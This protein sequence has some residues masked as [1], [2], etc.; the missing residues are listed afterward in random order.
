MKSGADL[1]RELIEKADHDLAAASIGARHGAPRDA[2]CFHVQQA[3]EK[4]LKAR[5]S[6]AGVPYPLTHDLDELLAL[7]TP[8]FPAVAAFVDRFESVAPC[9]VELRYSTS[10]YPSEE[11]V[12]AGLELVSGFRSLVSRLLPVQALPPAQWGLASPHGDFHLRPVD[13][14]YA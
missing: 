7:A 9:A 12:S 14:S 2:V 3:V 1:C 4:M 8:P 10:F 5:L 13:P 11:E 6:F